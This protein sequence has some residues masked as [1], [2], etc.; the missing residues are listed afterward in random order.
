MK[1]KTKR[2]LIVGG[3]LLS[4][5]LVLGILAYSMVNQSVFSRTHSDASCGN[6]A[7]DL[8]SSL[9]SQDDKS[10][11][12]RFEV[13]PNCILDGMDGGVGGNEK[14][15]FIIPN[16]PSDI[17][18]NHEFPGNVSFE[19]LSLYR[20]T[21]TRTPHLA[22]AGIKGSYVG[23]SVEP[24]SSSYGSTEFGS[25]WYMSYEGNLY[26]RATL[27]AYALEDPTNIHNYN[28]AGLSK[29]V[30]E[31]K[32]P[33]KPNQCLTD[34]QCNAGTSW[35]NNLNKCENNL[36]VN[37]VITEEVITQSDIDLVQEQL[38]N[39]ITS[40]SEIA[41]NTGFSEDKVKFILENKDSKNNLLLY[42]SLS[43]ILVF[44]IL[45]IVLIRRK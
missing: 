45:I 10:Y 43:V 30:M 6:N 35:G 25:G 28:L 21:N 23:C 27:E 39:D 37:E 26:C 42:L 7:Y 34:L 13:I 17:N 22:E 33:K 44:I 32:I 4:L 20:E 12:Y 36:C 1:N 11:T 38:D 40:V 15:V 8:S 41:Q 29:I 14:F 3:F 19:G 31:V 24:T 5:I 18:T 9:I 16:L 2:N